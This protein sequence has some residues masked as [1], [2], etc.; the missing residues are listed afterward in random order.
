[1]NYRVYIL[2]D[3]VDGRAEQV[4]QV[5]R[6]SLGVVMADVLEGPPG[7]IIVM[8]VPERQRLAKLVIEVLTV[9]EAVTENVR[10]L[11]IRDRASANTFLKA[12][13]QKSRN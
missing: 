11:P 8:E 13:C 2:L 6:S 12:S 1:M 10:L 5:L 7:V 4:A 3:I 9:V